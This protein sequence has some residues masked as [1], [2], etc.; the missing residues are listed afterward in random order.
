M[1]VLAGGVGLANDDA[2]AGA[3]AHV[4]RKLAARPGVHQ[5]GGPMSMATLTG[6]LMAVATASVLAQAPPPAAAGPTFE[7]VSI[8][9]NT[10]NALGSNGSSERPDGGF[11]LLNIPVIT[12]IARAYAVGVPADYVG[13]PAWANTERYDVV[14]TSSLSKPTQEQRAAMMRAM[15]ADRFKLQV[16]VENREEAVYNLVVARSDRLG[17]NLKPVDVDCE[18]KV[19]ADRAAADAARAAGAPP[20]P[21]EFSVFGGPPPLC[22]IRMM[23]D[24]IDGGAKIE[25]LTMWLRQAA[26]R[27]IVDKTGLTGYYTV[28]LTYD[29]MAG[30]RGPD[31]AP[32]ADAAPSVFTAV[33]EQLGLKLEPARVSR[34]T[35]VIDRLE[36]PTE[37]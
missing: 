12:L 34:Q 22:S 28:T 13:R 5:V 29:R 16:H 37:N 21:R 20:P 23:G 33:Q 17:P 14:A 19:A 1:V 31:A 9:R 30:L 35:L 2:S 7:V 6:P 4:A 15:L 24:R 18:A 32:A 27:P 3:V 26:G 11:T 10:S 25:F 36:R 8:K